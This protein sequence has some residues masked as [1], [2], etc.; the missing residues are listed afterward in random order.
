MKEHKQDLLQLAQLPRRPLN[1]AKIDL[2]RTEYPLLRNVALLHGW[3]IFDRH[4]DKR[5]E[6]TLFWRDNYVDE[7]EFNKLLPYQRINHFP[8][9]QELG[10]KRLLALNVRRLASVDP[11][12]YSFV[13]RTWL[14]PE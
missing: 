13:P 12:E 9:S 11:A 8:G 7:D 14:L 5:E 10:N 2:G 6:V 4:L 3:K 1:R